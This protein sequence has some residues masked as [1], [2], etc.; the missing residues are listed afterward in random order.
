MTVGVVLD[1]VLAIRF[2]CVPLTKVLYFQYAIFLMCVGMTM[3]GLQISLE[4]YRDALKGGIAD[5]LK[6]NI[7]NYNPVTTK[8]DMIQS[9]VFEH[10]YFFYISA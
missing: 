3:G 1:F 4:S 5:G 10:L 9:T 6:R 2:Q 7:Q 8:V